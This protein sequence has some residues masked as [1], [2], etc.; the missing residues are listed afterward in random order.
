[1]PLTQEER[2]LR[3]QWRKRLASSGFKDIELPD[4]QLAPPERAKNEP[5]KRT[6]PELAK[7][8]ERE[9]YEAY[10]TRATQV[11]ALRG[12]WRLRADTRNVWKLHAQG[13]SNSEI[14]KQLAITVK[15]VRTAISGVR[16]MARLP[17]SASERSS[18]P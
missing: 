13:A 2:A 11:M 3:A 1:M 14:A 7:P 15:K 18:H 5:G 12:F 9:A 10:Y 16:K 4:G 8:V 6:S 17:L